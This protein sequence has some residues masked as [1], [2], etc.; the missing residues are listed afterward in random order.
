MIA[1]IAEKT[2]I[3]AE[4]ENVLPQRLLI[5]TIAGKWFPYDRFFSS[6]LAA[7]TANVTIIW[8]PGLRGLVYRTNRQFFWLQ[9]DVDDTQRERLKKQK[10]CIFSIT[11]FS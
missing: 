1:T 5:A 11:F 2:A 8:N 10:V 9:N 6:A 4:I 7:I 3:A